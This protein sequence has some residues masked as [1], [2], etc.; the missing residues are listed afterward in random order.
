MCENA[1][2]TY[3]RSLDSAALLQNGTA[4]SWSEESEDWNGGPIAECILWCEEFSSRGLLHRSFT[5]FVLA[6]TSLL[7]LAVIVGICVPWGESIYNHELVELLELW[8]VMNASFRSSCLYKQYND[9]PGFFAFIGLAG[10]NFDGRDR[11]PDVLWYHHQGNVLELL[12]PDNSSQWLIVS[13]NARAGVKFLV[14]KRPSLSDVIRFSKEC[15]I[16]CGTISPDRWSPK[17]FADCFRSHR[18]L[19]YN[20]FRLNC[21]HFSYWVFDYFKPQNLGCMPADAVSQGQLAI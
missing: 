18:Q 4:R 20:G 8:H 21:L 10:R 17:R 1:S 19:R 3:S 16:W 14:L 2:S 13:F 15:F 9:G 7:I 5:Y 11:S 6:A 12:M